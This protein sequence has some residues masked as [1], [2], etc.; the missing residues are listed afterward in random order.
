MEQVR[1]GDQRPPSAGGAMSRATSAK[2]RVDSALSRLESMVEERLR[3]ESTRADDLA[4]RAYYGIAA[5][6]SLGTDEGDLLDNLGLVAEALAGALTQA[7]TVSATPADY[8][9]GVFIVA[10]D[11]QGLRPL[12]DFTADVESFI[13]YIKA[14]GSMTRVART[15]YSH[16]SVITKSGIRLSE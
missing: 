7:G 4:K 5:T 1:P 2:D 8:L 10:I 13:D 3:A 14:K 12:A 16:K 6:M 9:Q 15:E 11:V